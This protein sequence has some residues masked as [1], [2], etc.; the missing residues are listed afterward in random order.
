MPFRLPPECTPKIVC[1]KTTAQGKARSE[2]GALAEVIRRRAPQAGRIGFETGA[3]ASWLWHELK[4]IDL[5]V[6][7]IDA[8]HAHAALS[9]RITSATPTAAFSNVARNCA[10][11]TVSA[12]RA[13]ICS[14]LNSA[15]KSV[16]PTFP[17]ARRQGTM[18]QRTQ[19]MRPSWCVN[20]SS[21]CGTSSPA[22]TRHECRAH[23]LMIC[24]WKNFSPSTKQLRPRS[25]MH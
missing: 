13:S 2:P 25:P 6:V 17:L 11:L 4:R 8:R 20:W 16:P 10:S 7:C 9:V 22:S 23:C 21:S 5:P 3:M 14:V 18:D 15:N 12:R 19:S 24:L 1:S